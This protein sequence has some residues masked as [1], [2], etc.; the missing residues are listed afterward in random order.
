[1]RPVDWAIVE[2]LREGRN[3]APN[4]AERQGY[5]GQYVR[6]RLGYLASHDVVVP[7]GNGLYELDENEV[8]E[9]EDGDESA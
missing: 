1:M 6:E 5:S 4:I 2:V 9:R 3:I 8:P 7:L